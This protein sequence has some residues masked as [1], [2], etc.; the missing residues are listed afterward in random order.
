M[1]KAIA[2]LIFALILGLAL[3]MSIFWL[4]QYAYEDISVSVYEIAADPVASNPSKEFNDMLFAVQIPVLFDDGEIA[5][6]DLEAYV[7]SV[8]LCE[9]PASFEM[10]ALKAQSVVARTYALKQF[11]ECGKHLN[12]AVCTD[13]ACCQGYLTTEGYSEKGGEY[14]QIIKMRDAVDATRGVVLTYG[15]KLID[16]TYFSCSGG[17]TE[18]ALAVWGTDIPYLRST[19]S[20]GEEYSANYVR[21]IVLSLDEFQELLG[22]EKKNIT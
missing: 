20:P 3:P 13:P 8:L 16:A 21:T 11:T 4:L 15:G 10:E 19:Q 6:I 17:M 5:M 2:A 9:M 12:A 14:A 1:R 7:L 18:D 22:M